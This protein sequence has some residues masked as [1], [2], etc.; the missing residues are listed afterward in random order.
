MQYASPATVSR[1]GMVFVDSRNLGYMPY[2]STWLVSRYVPTLI[3][4]SVSVIASAKLWSRHMCSHVCRHALVLPKFTIMFQMV[5]NQTC[6]LA[7]WNEAAGHL[8]SSSCILDCMTCII[9]PAKGDCVSALNC[10]PRQE[11]Q[12]GG[13][14]AEAAV[15]QVCY[16][17]CGLCPGGG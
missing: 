11:Q 9:N 2:V 1:C 8:N 12:C 5:A 3:A 13:W 4:T 16:P 14:T 7:T 17:C 10:L 6:K 15:C